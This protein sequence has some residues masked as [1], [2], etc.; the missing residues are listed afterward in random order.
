MPL[1]LFS[2][3]KRNKYADALFICRNIV[4]PDAE[5]EGCD[6]IAVSNGLITYIGTS[7][8]AESMIGPDTEVVELDGYLTAGFT[9]PYAD[10]AE[11]VLEGAYFRL[12]EGASESRICS[13]V[14]AW[15]ASNPAA[16]YCLA[17]DCPIEVFKNSVPA[18]GEEKSAFVKA[19]DE[20]SGEIP[21]C[22]IAE[23]GMNVLLNSAAAEMVRKRAEEYRV[24]S[25]S[26]EFALDTVF[27]IDYDSVS[28][29]LF[30]TACDYASRGYTSLLGNSESFFFDK[31]YRQ[32]LTECY[33]ADMLLQRYYGS[34]RLSRALPRNSVLYMLSQNRTSCTELDDKINYD[35]ITIDLSSD[36]E[37]FS[38]MDVGYVKELC[39][40]LADKGYSVRV[41]AL[42]R[43]S[44]LIAIDILGNLSDSYPRLSFSVLHD[45]PLTMGE[46][47]MIFTGRV[48]EDSLLH[49]GQL[50]TS[51][52][53]AVVAL[54]EDNARIAGI[55]GFTGRL[56]EG[57]AADFAVF[58]E[59][60]LAAKTA[61]AFTALRASKTILAG[62]VV[63]DA[64]KDTPQSLS[65][66]FSEQLGLIA[67]EL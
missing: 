54:S 45:Q 20:V 65:A 34:M 38:C 48:S 49:P 58:D 12:S 51:G 2:I 33:G 44:A 47:G 67:E 32:I 23:D 14:M 5:L 50:K 66:L 18:E 21:V 46:R 30:Y 22:V 63:Y 37:S 1:G 53:D 9:D 28:K 6:A 31:I 16:E 10:P 56:A 36:K 17:S 29:K 40:E 13:E 42:D 11:K 61:E 55:S 3:F 26:P 57:M 43:Q 7:L 52:L 35:N 4:T 60:P 24:F 62:K 8:E 27:S 19:L 59:D 15:L 41:N 64:S 39:S 25:V